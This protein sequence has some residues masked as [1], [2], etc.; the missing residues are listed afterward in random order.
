MLE[1]TRKARRGKGKGQRVRQRQ[2][3]SLGELIGIGQVAV[4]SCER[5]Q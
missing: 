2:L 1:G 3:V 5:D 4:C